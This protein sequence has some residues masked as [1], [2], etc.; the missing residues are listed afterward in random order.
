MFKMHC[1]MYVTLVVYALSMMTTVCA[2]PLP[3]STPG[4]KQ[5]LLK[6]LQHNVLAPK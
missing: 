1:F 5:Y 6:T 4:L 2:E 3:T